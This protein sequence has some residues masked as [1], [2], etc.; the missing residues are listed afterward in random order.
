MI[1]CENL[2]KIYQIA[3]LEL[4]ALQGLELTVQRGELM[5]IVGASGSGKTTLMNVLGGLVRPSAGRVV[6]NGQELLKLSNAALDRYRRTQVG[7]VWQQ[8][9]RNL[10][11]YLNAREN[12]ELPMML[13]G[14][15]ARQMRQRAIELLEMV[16]L[17]QRQNHYLSELS[18]GEQQRVAIAVALANR[19]ELLLA[20]EPTGELDSATALTIYEAL[21]Q[22]NAELGLTILIVSHDPTIARHVQRVMAIRDGKTASETV[23]KKR[24]HNG[25]DDAAAIQPLGEDHFEELVVLDSAGRLQLPKAYREALGIRQRVRMEMTTD[26]LLIRPLEEAEMSA[27]TT[28]GTMVYQPTEPEKNWVSRWLGRLRR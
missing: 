9:A 7:F 8:G 16:G 5:G 15:S 18:G 17:S 23:R 13:V 2:V 19:P 25:D 12:I 24:N 4:L 28:P 26:G 27:H 21:Q 10:V 6:V 14:L 1:L 3:D 22:L 20:D 11:P